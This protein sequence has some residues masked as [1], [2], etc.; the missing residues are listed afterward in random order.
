MLGYNEEVHITHTL[1]FDSQKNTNSRHQ[2]SNCGMYLYDNNKEIRLLVNKQTGI[3]SKE[4]IIQSIESIIQRLK[5]LQNNIKKSNK[6]KVYIQMNS[7]KRFD[8]ILIQDDYTIGGLIETWNN[9]N[10][11]N[12]VTG[13]KKSIDHKSIILDFGVKDLDTKEKESEVINIFL[14]SLESIQKY[15]DILLQDAKKIVVKTIPIPKYMDNI[16]EFRKMVM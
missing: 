13:C 14:Q 12:T 9:H 1:E 10:I 3:D 6:E 4:L 5:E 15:M 2:A 7:N 8:F 16:Q 11:P